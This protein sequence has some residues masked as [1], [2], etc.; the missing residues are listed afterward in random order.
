MNSAKIP[1]AGRPAAFLDRDGI[2]NL[3]SGYV[4]LRAQFTWRDGAVEAVKLLNDGGYLV[5][6]V[7]NQS[8]V[9]HGYFGEKQVRELHDWMVGQLERH[10]ARIDAF[11]YCPHHPQGIQPE[12]A[13]DCDC[14]KPKPGM[15]LRALKEWTIDR[16]QS[17]LLGDKDSDVQAATAAGVRGFLWRTGDLRDAVEAAISATRIPPNSLSR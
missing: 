17:F 7:T 9:A 1:I 3:D 2:L 4:H 14:R 8:G 16:S 5:F 10:G 11:Y 13:I 12:Y 6:V 15:L